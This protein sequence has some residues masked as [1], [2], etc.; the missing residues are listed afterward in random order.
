MNFWARI[1][2]KDCFLWPLENGKVS[3]QMQLSHILVF[4]LYSIVISAPDPLR[5]PERPAL[6]GRPLIIWGGGMVRTFANNFFFTD[7]LCSFFFLHASERFFF[8]FA[9]RPPND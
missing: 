5:L 1:F 8:R 6:W 3:S 9:P 2:E 7:T 4:S